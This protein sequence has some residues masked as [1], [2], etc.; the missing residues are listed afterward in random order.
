MNKED[1]NFV[2]LAFFLYIWQQKS[3]FMFKIYSV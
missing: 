3:G 2:C 1:E